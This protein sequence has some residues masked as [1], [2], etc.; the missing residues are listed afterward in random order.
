MFSDG[1]KEETGDKITN[2]TKWTPLFIICHL[3]CIIQAY[4]FVSIVAVSIL[5]PMRNI[6]DVWLYCTDF[7]KLLEVIK[8][9]LQQASDRKRGEPDNCHFLQANQYLY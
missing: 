2:S 4:A 9:L 8:Y 5:P 7:Q 3:F 1:P 6:C